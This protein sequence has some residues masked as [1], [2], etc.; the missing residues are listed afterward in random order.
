MN[1]PILFSLLL[2]ISA[3]I[4]IKLYLECVNMTGILVALSIAVIFGIGWYII[5]QN[6][7]PHLLYHVDY[8]SDKQVCS[9]PSNNILN[10]MFTKTGN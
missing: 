5:I 8:I 9:M 1:Y 6:T 4:A 3:D 10:V 2:L 7:D